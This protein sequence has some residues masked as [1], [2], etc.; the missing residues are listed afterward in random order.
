MDPSGLDPARAPSSDFN[1]RDPRHGR[2]VLHARSGR[3]ELIPK[4]ARI[5]GVETSQ[6]TE[7][8]RVVRAG[9][10]ALSALCV[11]KCVR[12]SAGDDS[13]A[14]QFGLVVEMMNEA[15][16]PLRVD[17]NGLNGSI[18]RGRMSARGG[19]LPRLGLDPRQRAW[20]H[21]RKTRTRTMP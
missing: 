8:D 3:N 11:R 21:L 16:A 18:R 9:L 20:I 10:C 15:V 4:N 13:V 1:Q 17:P 12:Q 2:P 14:R 5:A 7:T 19:A 6:W